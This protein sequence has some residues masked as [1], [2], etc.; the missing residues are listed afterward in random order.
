M[1]YEGLRGAQAS[2]EDPAVLAAEKIPGAVESSGL[3]VRPLCTV[4]FALSLS[5]HKGVGG[6]EN[7][8]PWARVSRLEWGEH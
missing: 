3:G 6:S 2:L 4:V 8:L 7:I 5:Y 1:L